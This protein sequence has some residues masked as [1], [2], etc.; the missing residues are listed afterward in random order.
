MIRLG[1]V[2][3][4]LVKKSPRKD[5]LQRS[6]LHRV[7]QL[8]RLGAGGLVDLVQL[9]ILLPL[10]MLDVELFEVP[11]L[12]GLSDAFRDQR[13]RRRWMGMVDEVSNAVEETAMFM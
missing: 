13:L 8:V 9:D 11:G 5:L 2:K 1:L 3:F 10:E 6:H 4:Y 7:R 12:F